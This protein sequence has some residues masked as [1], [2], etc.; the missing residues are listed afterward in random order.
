MS[1][2]M[3]IVNESIKNESAVG[4]YYTNADGERTFRTVVFEGTI[5]NYGIPLV[6]GV[7]TS[8]Q[9]YRRFYVN[10]MENVEFV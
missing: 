7:D 8:K 4:F 1:N 10:H 2:V 6:V 5:S 3:N 9:E